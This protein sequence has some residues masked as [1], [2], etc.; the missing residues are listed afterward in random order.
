MNIVWGSPN[1]INSAANN[2]V[3]FYSGANGQGNEIGSVTTSDLVAAFAVVNTNTPGYLIT[4]DTTAVGPFQSVVF[5]TGPAAFE[6]A[7]TT[8]VP[9]PATWAMVILGFGAMSFI[10]DRRKSS[11]RRLTGALCQL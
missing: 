2:V 4:F 3:T 1:D 9:E 8:A 5:S 10:A 7:F 11:V 6:F